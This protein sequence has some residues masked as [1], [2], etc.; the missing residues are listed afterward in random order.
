MRS[1]WLWMYRIRLDLPQAKLWVGWS[2]QAN[3]HK[4]CT[5]NDNHRL[6]ALSI[7]DQAFSF[8]CFGVKSNSVDN[9]RSSHLESGY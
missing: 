5:G 9:E 2:P 7:G 4:D 3:I 6:Q 1:T 8:T